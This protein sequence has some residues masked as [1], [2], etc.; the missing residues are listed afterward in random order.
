MWAET[1]LE[2]GVGTT[3]ELGVS[4]EDE[5]A[6][7]SDEYVSVLFSEMPEYDGPFEVTPSDEEQ[8]LRTAGTASW[9]DVTIA[10]IP[11][12]YGRITYSG[13]VLTVS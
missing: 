11:S 8:V 4:E 12:N 1:E 13:N 5:T 9:Y 2:V 10:P 6:F 3:Y 7:S